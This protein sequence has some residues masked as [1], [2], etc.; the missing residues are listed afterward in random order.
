[1]GFSRSN[2]SNPQGVGVGL[3]SG[4]GEGHRFESLFRK[5]WTHPGSIPDLPR[6]ESHPP[7][8]ILD[9]PIS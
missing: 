1:M 5:S 4:G 3:M 9:E 2:A 6:F 8:G 7:I